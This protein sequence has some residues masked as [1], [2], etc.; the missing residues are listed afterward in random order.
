[1]DWKKIESRKLVKREDA[2]QPDADQRG[3][4]VAKFKIPGCIIV[5]SDQEAFDEVPLDADTK[6]RIT[7]LVRSGEVVWPSDL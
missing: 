5:D 4:R 3:A 2:I 7:D 1:M 6:R